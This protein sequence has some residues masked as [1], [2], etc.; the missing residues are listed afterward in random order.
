MKSNFKIIISML[1]IVAVVLSSGFTT[2]SKSPP[3]PDSPTVIIEIEPDS[4]DGKNNEGAN[5]A[6]PQIDESPDEI[7][8]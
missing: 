2:I 1:I 4:D 5:E 3:S 6:K 7:D 8:Q